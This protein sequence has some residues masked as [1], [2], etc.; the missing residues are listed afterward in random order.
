MKP[1]FALAAVAAALLSTAAAAQM[2]HGMGHHGA[3]PGMTGAQGAGPVD[4]PM[5]KGMAGGHGMGP[6][7]MGGHGMGPGMMGGHGMMG[8]PGMMGGF[9]GLEGLGLNAEQQ[10]KVREIQRDLQRKQHA[11]MG[12]LRELRW[13]E[14]DAAKSPAFDEAAARKRYEAQ[15]AASKQMFE[16]RLEA[17]KRI[18][19]LLTPEQREQLRR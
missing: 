4:C 12:S 10:S 15:A 3:G 6:G 18:Q 17:H 11:T 8:G 13:Q 16:A 2:G 9:R 7:M 14:E 1:G 5:G 19:E